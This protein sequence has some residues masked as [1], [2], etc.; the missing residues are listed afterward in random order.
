M[1]CQCC[2][3]NPASTYIKTISG[4][5][6]TEYAL[7]AECAQQLGCGNLF[8]GLGYHLSDIVRE[9]FDESDE[10]DDVRCKCCGSSFND[11]VRSGRVGCA[12]CYNT[13]YDRLLPVIR[14]IHGS[15]VHRGKVPGDSL[16]QVQSGGPLAVRERDEAKSAGGRDQ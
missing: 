5:K 11:I 15:D 16:P 8:T 9:F 6:L 7:C 13:F 10:E 3:R 2:G 14:Q 4:G 12:E 1:I